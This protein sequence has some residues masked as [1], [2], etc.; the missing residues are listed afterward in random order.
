MSDQPQTPTIDLML[1]RQRRFEDRFEVLAKEIMR[2]LTEGF[3]TVSTRLDAIEARIGGLESRM[4]GVEKI[5]ARFSADS[6]LLTQQ[7]DTAR[8]APTRRISVSTH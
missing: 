6:L 5:A 1:A 4:S 3:E 7:I 2:S 8:T